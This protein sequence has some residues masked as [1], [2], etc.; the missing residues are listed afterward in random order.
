MID[1][2]EHVIEMAPLV[3]RLLD[4]SEDLVVL[5]TSR[6]RL[7]L[8]DE[9]VVEVPPLAVTGRSETAGAIRL[10]SPQT[11]TCAPWQKS[12]ATSARSAH[13]RCCTKR[14]SPSGASEN[15]GRMLT[16]PAASQAANSSRY[17]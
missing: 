2:C 14:T 6:E 4:R 7:R 10:P 11:Y 5:A 15:A 16:A 9:R 8:R 1:N 12:R 13:S 3:A 17:R